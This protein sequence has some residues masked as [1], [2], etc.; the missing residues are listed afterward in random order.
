M[1][2]DKRSI[3]LVVLAQ[4]S[5]SSWLNT[6]TTVK[7]DRLCVRIGMWLTSKG[8]M[9]CSGYKNPKSSHNVRN[10]HVR[11]EMGQRPAPCSVGH[12]WRSAACKPLG[13]H[14]EDGVGGASSGRRSRTRAQFSAGAHHRQTLAQ[15]WAGESQ[16]FV[17]FFI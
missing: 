8:M 6:K 16:N 2:S 1:E 17:L 11:Q 15:Q 14:V 4:F 10:V 13:A 9:S 3:D 5:L 7:I 12:I